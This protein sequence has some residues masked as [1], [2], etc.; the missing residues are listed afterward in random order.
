MKTPVRQLGTILVILLKYLV[1][2]NSAIWIRL[3][4][5]APMLSLSKSKFYFYFLQNKN[6]YACSGVFTVYFVCKIVLNFMPISF[7]SS[8]VVVKL[9]LIELMRH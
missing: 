7:T 2:S 1:K 5:P 8:R 3:S 9:R 6:T 4:D